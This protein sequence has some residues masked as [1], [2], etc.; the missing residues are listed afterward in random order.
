MPVDDVIGVSWWQRYVETQSYYLGFSYACALGF[1][2]VAL[3]RYRETRM[4]SART[5]AVGGVSLSG[6][7]AVAG[8]YLLGC[9]GS[10]MIGVYLSLFGAAFLPWA[11]PLVAAFTVLCIGAAWW[12]MNRAAAACTSCDPPTAAR[13]A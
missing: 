12:R 8:C 3:R 7:L 4:G 9:C 1:A 10:P 5:M 13:P 2:S 6:A 11:R